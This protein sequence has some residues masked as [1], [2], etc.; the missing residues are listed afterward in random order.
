MKSV[1]LVILLSLAVIS[2]FSCKKNKDEEVSP[3]SISGT[4]KCFEVEAGGDISPLPAGGMTAEIVVKSSD[5]KTATVDLHYTDNGKT[6][7]FPTQLCTVTTDAD[8]FLVLNK[9]NGGKLYLIYYDK[10]T[11]DCF[12]ELGIRFSGS[13]SGKKPSDWDD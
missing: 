8:G 12:P 11:V 4:F 7:H 13:R 9:K 10:E 5:L 6:S 3:E 2:D 1:C